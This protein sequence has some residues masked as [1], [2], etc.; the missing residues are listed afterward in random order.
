MTT[1][2]SLCRLLLGL[3]P[4]ACLHSMPPWPYTYQ[5]RHSRSA[6]TH[7]TSNSADQ[8]LPNTNIL[9]L[10]LIIIAT[11][12]IHMIPSK[13]SSPELP[14]SEPDPPP[15]DSPKPAE[16][17]VLHSIGKRIID[18]LSPTTETLHLHVTEPSNPPPPAAPQLNPEKS[19]TGIGNPAPRPIDPMKLLRLKSRHLELSPHKAS[20]LHISHQQRQEKINGSARNAVPPVPTPSN[21]S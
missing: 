6:Q 1:M 20:S 8:M 9:L 21:S 2:M 13:S 5:C 16:H 18:S 11:T 10:L 15:D 3:E 19:Y 12:G 4:S 14:S 7:L 17:G